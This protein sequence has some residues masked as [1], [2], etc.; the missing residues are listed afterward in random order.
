A[1]LACR[2]GV[3]PGEVRAMNMDAFIDGEQPW[4]VVAHAMKGGYSYAP[5][6]GAKERRV[7]RIPLDAVAVEWIRWRLEQRAAAMKVG[8]PAWALS[9]ALFPNPT[10][11]RT[12]HRW[13]GKALREEWARAADGLGV[14]ARLYEGTKHAFATDAVARGV[15]LEWVQKFLGHADRRSTE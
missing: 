5:R 13:L 6:R 14:E 10:G 7:R 4:L 8:S 12:Q 11:R 1:F 9:L 3:R 15:P 2:L